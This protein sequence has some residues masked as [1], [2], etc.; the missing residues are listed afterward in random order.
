MKLLV[1][2]VTI[3]LAGCAQL[4]QG[5]EQPVTQIGKDDLYITTCSGLA[6]TLGSCFD[7]ANK[8]CH[9]KY[10]IVKQTQDS[11]GVHRE[12]TFQCKK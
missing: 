8:T 3:S 6:E 12:L 2:I 5:Q 11:S 4:M 10:A 9:G 7:K 1:L